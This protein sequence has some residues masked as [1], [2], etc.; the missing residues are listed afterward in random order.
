MTHIR[1][2]LVERQNIDGRKILFSQHG[3]DRMVPGDIV[4]VEFWRNMLK[5]S[6]TSFVGICIGI[7]RKNIATSITLR[8]LI[9]KVGVE[10]KFKVYSPLIK[11]IKRVKLAE[12][13][14]RAKLFYV[15]DQPKKAKLSRAKGLM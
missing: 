9:L 4:Q 6:S 8:N 12:D 14:R 5:K 11:S 13:F 2:D 10:Q 1:N 7:D 3:K 15:R